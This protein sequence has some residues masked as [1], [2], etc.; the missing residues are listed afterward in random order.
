M[1]R[2][3]KIIIIGHF[4]GNLINF[5]ILSYVKFNSNTYFFLKIKEM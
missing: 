5:K 2:I 4:E 1:S 3:K